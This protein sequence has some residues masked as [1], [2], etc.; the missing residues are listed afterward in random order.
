MPD[1]PPMLMGGK[2]VM[3]R[4]GRTFENINP[5]TESSIG[6]IPDAHENDVAEAIGA[7]RQAFDETNWSI[8]QG[9]PPVVPRTAK[10]GHGG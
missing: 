2:L 1:V 10:G 6:A 4:D 5:A 3:A 7:A 9:L 8:D